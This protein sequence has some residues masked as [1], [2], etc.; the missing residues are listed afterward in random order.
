MPMPRAF[1]RLE[2]AAAMVNKL[3]GTG[4]AAETPEPTTFTTLLWVLRR[5]LERRL[6]ASSA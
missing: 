2:D 3:G 6:L 5:P 1:G 4:A